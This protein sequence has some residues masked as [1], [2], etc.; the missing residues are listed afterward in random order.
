MKKKVLSFAR[1]RL[2]KKLDEEDDNLGTQAVRGSVKTT[3]RVR[4]GIENAK[5]VKTILSKPAV[6]RSLLLIIGIFIG[7]LFLSILIGGIAESLMG[8]TT[9]HPELTAYVRQLDDQ[10]TEQIE[11]LRKNYENKN[12]YDVTIQGSDEINTDPNALAILTTGNWT[13]IELTEENKKKLK[14]CYDV[15]NTYKETKTDEKVKRRSDT[16]EESTDIKHHITITIIT[17]SAKDK[18][19]DFGFTDAQR[20]DVLDQLELLEQISGLGINDLVNPGADGEPGQAFDDPQVQALFTEANQYLGYP[21]VWGGSTP[22]TSFDCSGFVCWVFTH[23]RVHSLSRTTAQGL[24]DECTPVS[25]LEAKPGDL[26]FFTK[27]YPTSSTVTHVGIYA[28]NNRMIHC[29]DPIQYTT[30]DKSYWQEHFYSFGRL[31]G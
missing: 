3:W 21:Y 8:S 2:L 16:G 28:G 9:E 10:F 11:N 20:K 30:L 29:G 1:D 6:S 13:D 17:S 31:S 26:V 22:A 27:T 5:K 24:F 7:M 18:I 14:D 25:S 19:D 23:S 15:L 12:D 4:S